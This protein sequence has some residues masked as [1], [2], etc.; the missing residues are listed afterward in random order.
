M[1]SN[2]NNNYAHRT[3]HNLLF[4]LLLGVASLTIYFG[5][6]NKSLQVQME[7]LNKEMD[8]IHLQAEIHFSSSFTGYDLNPLEMKERNPP[9]RGK[10][11]ASDKSAISKTIIKMSRQLAIETDSDDLYILRR[12]NLA[13][14][15]DSELDNLE[16]ET[17][18][19]SKL[20]GE[21]DAI[22][23]AV[24]GRRPTVTI[25]KYNSGS[26][27]ENNDRHK[28]QL[29]AHDR[30]L[31]AKRWSGN[32]SEI[33]IVRQNGIPQANFPLGLCEGECDTDEDCIGSLVCFHRDRYGLLVFPG[34]IGG[35]TEKSRTD[36][37]VAKT[38]LAPL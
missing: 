23:K 9:V 3:T 19:F 8:K 12:F 38:S 33:R 4:G 30:R 22:V 31:Q 2:N 13:D 24:K 35:N 36:Y 15:L 11:L 25:E 10:I 29:R 1:S 27:N 7:N 16:T 26:T 17:R 28:N 20:T 34:C 14:A 21:Y 5:L 6:K 37:C 18:H 32:D